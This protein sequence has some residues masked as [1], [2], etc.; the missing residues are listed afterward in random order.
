MPYTTRAVL[1]AIVLVGSG[2]AGSTNA[3]ADTPN[4]DAKCPDV[5]LNE[6]HQAL[7]NT[8]RGQGQDDLE[9]ARNYLVFNHRK[10]RIEFP[11]PAQLEVRD[12]ETFA[13]VFACSNPSQ[14]DYVI[15]GIKSDAVP[16]SSA[17]I[18]QEA[19]A[20]P[21][22]LHA[23]VTWRHDR[24]VPLYQVTV[25]R[26]K[27]ASAEDNARTAVLASGL[28]GSIK[29]RGDADFGDL[30][31]GIVAMSESGAD[32]STIETYSRDNRLDPDEVEEALTLMGTLDKLYSYTFPIWVKTVG[33]RLSFSSGFGFSG[34][35]DEEYFTRTDDM[36]TPEDASD[37][38]KTV[39]R[40]SNAEDDFLPDLMA[41]AN[42]EFPSSNFGLAF[43]L[44]IG[45]EAEP[46]YFFGP[47]L[48]LGKQ[49]I[50]TGGV[51]GGKVSTLPSGQSLGQAPINGDN[52]L[53]NLPTKFETA[54]YL[55]IAF[56]FSPAQKEF[57]GALTGAQQIEEE[58]D[59]DAAA[60][61]KA[62]EACEATVAKALEM[63]KESCGTVFDTAKATC[64][65]ETDE[66]VKT[67]CLEAATKAKG[68]CES[69][70]DKVAAA[71]KVKCKG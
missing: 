32:R 61:K 20:D 19:P 21:V 14:F 70:A 44:G 30:L 43:G 12:G 3:A 17:T 55:G 27:A 16:S 42:L 63:M 71:E 2:N 24:Q 18:Q 10:G 45:D 1:I 47:S 54:F 5:T 49:F 4:I 58:G 33:W 39:E 50:L 65:A 26:R 41:L 62:Q 35:T 15:E 34:L 68:E 31:A 11:V 28:R 60:K 38:V 8:W 52:T 23:S 48:D 56:K 69:Q 59:A 37:D 7:P 66:A 40:D 6:I 51:A 9:K 57:L 22:G 53:N 29:G 46:R 13:I 64:E 67:Q 25:K 36:G